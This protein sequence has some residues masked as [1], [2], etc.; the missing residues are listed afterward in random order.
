MPD[1]RDTADNDGR[2]LCN[3]LSGVPEL[4]PRARIR[5]QKLCRV[6]GTQS[7]QP[8]IANLAAALR[9]DRETRATHAH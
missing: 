4:F 6:V 3:L 7:L 9:P 2:V 1:D 5:E 8:E